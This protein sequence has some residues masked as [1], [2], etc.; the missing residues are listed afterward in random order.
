MPSTL[1]VWGWGF[2]CTDPGSFHS[3]IR[4]PHLDGCWDQ[5]KSWRK[6]K[7][8]DRANQQRKKFLYNVN[9][10]KIQEIHNQ[11]LDKIFNKN[12]IKGS[13]KKKELH[14]IKAGSVRI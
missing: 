7:K 2:D 8:H 9:F 12:L 3:D 6:G 1:L 11:E 13:D 14:K 5:K 4:W 10:K